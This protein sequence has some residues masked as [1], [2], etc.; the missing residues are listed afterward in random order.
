MNADDPLAGIWD[1]ARTNGD[2][3]EELAWFH[4]LPRVQQV[5]YSTHHLSAEV[6]NGGF[7]QYFHNSTGLTAPEAVESFRT[8][9]LND[10]ADLVQEAID[11]FGPVFPRERALRQEFLDSI[12][13]DEPSDWNPFFLLDDR[14]DNII[15]IPGAPPLND[16]DRY[17]LAAREFISRTVP[18]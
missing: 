11:V 15:M 7:H 8:L 17:T 14:F 16:E 10:V 12:P 2:S 9:G 5:I 13:G 1:D 6:Y 4:R 3:A 18:S